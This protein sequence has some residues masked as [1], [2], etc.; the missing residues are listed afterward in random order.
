MKYY[1]TLVIGV[2][3]WYQGKTFKIDVEQ[4]VTKEEAEYL[5]NKTTQFETREEKVSKVSKKKVKEE[6]GE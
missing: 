4:E 2:D 6:D 5:A 1:A 3:Y